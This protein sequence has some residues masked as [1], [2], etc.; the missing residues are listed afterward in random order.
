MNIA[1]Q[2]QSELNFNKIVS[3]LQR[4]MGQGK[5]QVFIPS[6]LATNNI[7]RLRAEGFQVNNEGEWRNGGIYVS[8]KT[9]NQWSDR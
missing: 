4:E 7:E 1:E 3:Q 6:N 2:L 9:K 5:T 8:F